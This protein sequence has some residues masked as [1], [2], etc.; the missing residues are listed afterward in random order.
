MDIEIHGLWYHVSPCFRPFH[1]IFCSLTQG[2]Q[3]ESSLRRSC[4]QDCFHLAVAIPY[5]LDLSMSPFPLY[6]EP[7]DVLRRLSQSDP[8]NFGSTRRLRS[9]IL[10]HELSC[11]YILDLAKEVRL[12]G[13]DSTSEFR[14]HYLQPTNHDQ[15][16]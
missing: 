4:C 13:S 1:H 9:I 14:N 2:H 11:N 6:H 5:S 15:K 8:A 16:Y 12:A 3:E 10:A 7:V